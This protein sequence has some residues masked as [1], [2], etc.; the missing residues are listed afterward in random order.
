MPSEG[1]E[2]REFLKVDICGSPRKRISVR[3][4]EQIFDVSVHPIRGTWSRQD[5]GVQAGAAS[6]LVCGR[7]RRSGAD[8]SHRNTHRNAMKGRPRRRGRNLMPIHNEE[9]EICDT[10]NA[11]FDREPS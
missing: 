3:I 11:D 6:S 1:P 7:N 9:T 10:F 2:S 4:F 5:H 8:F